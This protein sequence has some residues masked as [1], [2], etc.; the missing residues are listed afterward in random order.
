MNN[1]LIA[2]MIVGGA[3][4]TG[5]AFLVGFVHGINVTVRDYG[6]DKRKAADVLAVKES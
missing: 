5:I 1:L 4:I 6:E 2:L 3:C